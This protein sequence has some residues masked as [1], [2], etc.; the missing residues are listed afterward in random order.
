MKKWMVSCFV[1]FLL[2]LSACSITITYDDGTDD[3]ESTT[4]SERISDEESTDKP[5]RAEKPDHASSGDGQWT[6]GVK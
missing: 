5:D 4:I 2:F 1:F 6:E 3:S